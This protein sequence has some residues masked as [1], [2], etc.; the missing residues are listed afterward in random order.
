MS[1]ALVCEAL[2]RVW[3]QQH[4]AEAFLVAGH[5]DGLVIAELKCRFSP[6]SLR[7]VKTVA[8]AWGLVLVGLAG[9]S[10]SLI[11]QLCDERRLL[12]YRPGGKGKRVPPRSGRLHGDDSGRG[13]ATLFV[14]ACTARLATKSLSPAPPAAPQV[15]KGIATMTAAIQRVS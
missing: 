14:T 11:Y 10:V 3:L 7:T 12:H 5:I 4:G 13:S 9:V 15:S 8:A 2:R 6:A 1:L